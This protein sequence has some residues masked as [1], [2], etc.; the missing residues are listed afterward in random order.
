[1]VLLLEL[2]RLFPLLEGRRKNHHCLV[3]RREFSR[4]RHRASWSIVLLATAEDGQKIGIN[5]FVGDWM[6]GI[7]IQRW[8]VDGC[9]FSDGQI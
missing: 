4:T 1:M 6:V 9:I 3:S 2:L 8:K 5:D 7:I